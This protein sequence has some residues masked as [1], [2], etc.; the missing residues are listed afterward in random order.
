MNQNFNEWKIY[1]LMREIKVRR[2]IM[3]CRETNNIWNKYE[4]DCYESAKK[5][6]F[7]DKKDLEKD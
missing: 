3:I 5:E 2:Y 4:Q 7:N 6:F 1:K